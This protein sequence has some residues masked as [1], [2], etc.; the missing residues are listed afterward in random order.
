MKETNGEM[1]GKKGK[2][3]VGY[4]AF[5]WIPIVVA[6]IFILTLV[7]LMIDGV[8]WNSAAVAAC[9]DAGGK[10]DYM[11][12]ERVCIF[13]GGEAHFV[14]F[15]CTGWFSNNECTMTVINLG[16]FRTK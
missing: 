2:L 4:V 14:M 16:D 8:F 3:A 15:Y 12:G 10:T 5:V 6:A 1:S 13:P 11:M 7:A 9:A